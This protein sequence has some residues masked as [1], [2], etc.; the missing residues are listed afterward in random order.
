ML[1]ITCELT[2]NTVLA[3]TEQHSVDATDGFV[4]A[5]F[6]N[7]AGRTVEIRALGSTGTVNRLG[8]LK[9]GEKAIEILSVGNGAVSFSCVD[10]DRPGDDIVFVSVPAR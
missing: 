9:D 7:E 4:R 10:D 5:S 2:A 8:V 6:S 3:T 1:Q